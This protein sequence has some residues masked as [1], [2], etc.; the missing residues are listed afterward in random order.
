MQTFLPYSDFHKSA[1]LL[2]RQRLGKQRVEV[3]QILKTLK[4]ESKGWT[5]HPAVKMWRGYENAL[6]LY[7]L[8]ICTEW[9]GRGYKDTIKER[10][11]SMIDYNSSFELPPWFGGNIH[12]SHRSN[13]IRKK[14]EFY[15]SKFEKDTRL[16][17]PYL[18][19]VI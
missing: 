10:L 16:N 4:G 7:G 15:L 19:P 14:P 11:Y 17:L 13:L 3:Y 5:N 9:I 18:W 2:D 1:C 6:I 8:E 12:E